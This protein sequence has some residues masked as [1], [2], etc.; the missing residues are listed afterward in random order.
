MR[1]LKWILILLVILIFVW[2]LY[3]KLQER[4]YEP[5]QPGGKYKNTSRILKD[6]RYLYNGKYKVKSV[7]SWSADGYSDPLMFEKEMK[8]L[9]NLVKNKDNEVL[10]IELTDLV[11][12]K[13][14][15]DVR[16]KEIVTRE[17]VHILHFL[18]KR[19]LE[20]HVKA[21]QVHYTHQYGFLAVPKTTSII[22][23]LEE[24]INKYDEYQK[25]GDSADI[26]FVKLC[27]EFINY[28]K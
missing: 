22:I 12:P 13:S 24:F 25:Q 9:G 8:V 17:A 20:V 18:T 21:V 10:T 23:P 4:Y 5:V 2:L 27:L 1:T 3:T 26:R 19:E 16:D 15:E 11:K 6:L 14:H 7:E 28:S